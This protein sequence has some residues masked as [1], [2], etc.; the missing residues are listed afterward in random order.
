MGLWSKVI[1]AGGLFLLPAC[2]SFSAQPDVP[3]VIVHPT[4]ASRAALARA[5]GA[6]LQGAPVTLADD[7]LTRDSQLLIEPVHPR[8]ANGLP[9]NGR[10][11]GRPEQFRLVKNGSR[12]VL[13]HQSTGKRQTL[14]STKC[15]PAARAR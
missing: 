2:E 7:A 3:A 9:L 10:E 4:A 15:A 13:I 12:C 11:L 5:V 1:V 14:R 6:A 8:D